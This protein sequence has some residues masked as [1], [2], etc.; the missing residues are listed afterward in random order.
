VRRFWQL[1]LMVLLAISFAQV[2]WWLVDQANHTRRVKQTLTELYAQDGRAA[3]RL[4]ERDVEADEVRQLYPHV[5]VAED[6]S[7][8]SVA[9]R[10]RPAPLLADGAGRGLPFLPG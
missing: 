10:P 1:T 3:L 5:S 7:G 6:G 8:V 2:A 4:L 9:P